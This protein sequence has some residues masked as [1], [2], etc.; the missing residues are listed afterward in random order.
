[1]YHAVCVVTCSS[2]S[3]WLLP[4]IIRR[5]QINSFNGRKIR[6]YG[7]IGRLETCVL[8][9]FLDAQASQFSKRVLLFFEIEQNYGRSGPV[10]R[11]IN[12]ASP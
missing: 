3:L 9:M 12:L 11:L 7:S 4:V 6:K 1:M 8:K 5:Y 2:V 10:K